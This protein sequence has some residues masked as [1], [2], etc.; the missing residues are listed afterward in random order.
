MKTN[1]MLVTPEMA[2]QWLEVN[3]DNRRMRPNVVE[4]LRT[5]W[6][7]G[8][9][10]LTH[11][12]IAFAKNGKLLDGQHR[13]TFVSQLPE[14]ATVA[15]NVS[16]DC[17][18]DL[19][20]AID[21]GAR[22]TLSDITGM[23]GGLVAVGRLLAK[24]VNGSSTQ[25]LTPQYVAPFIKWAE[26]AFSELV[27]FSPGNALVWSSAPVRAAAVYQINQGHDADYIKVSYDSL[28]R[29][30]IDAMPHA[31]RA[32]MQQRMSGKIVSARSL[33]LF[34]RAL[35]AFDST[36]QGKIKSINVSDQAGTLA[37]AR[38]HLEFL[39]KKSPAE[40]GL[41]VAKPVVKFNRKA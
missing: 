10:K 15:M 16:T 36:R 11:Q 20:G 4:D 25:G 3:T 6:D 38:M 32:L 40:A 1:L 27:T 13:L 28:M 19:F 34:C 35:R 12:G 22:R 24:I 37:E 18:N 39:A 29:A 5:A 33:D 21:Q 23:S 26:P 7:R 14:G 30:D 2:R 31:A 9:W 8:E 41:K 17:E